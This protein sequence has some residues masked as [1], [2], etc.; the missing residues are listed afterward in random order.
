MGRVRCDGQGFD[1]RAVREGSRN[2]AFENNNHCF[3][4]EGGGKS[5]SSTWLDD[6]G[7]GVGCWKFKDW[8]IR[9]RV[10]ERRSPRSHFKD[11]TSNCRW[12]S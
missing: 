11:S 6:E 3:E 1:E 7:Y 12:C 10:E 5:F 9:F 2:W 8:V 4:W